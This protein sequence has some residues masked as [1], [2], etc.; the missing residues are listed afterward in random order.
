LGVDSKQW[1]QGN[2]GECISIAVEGSN[3][4]TCCSFNTG[5]HQCTGIAKGVKFT[6]G[7]RLSVV[8]TPA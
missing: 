4:G 1:T 6:S 3:K 2:H 5:W 7:S 8:L